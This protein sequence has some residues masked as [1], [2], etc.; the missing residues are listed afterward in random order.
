MLLG[1]ACNCNFL[2]EKWSI[3]GLMYQMIDRMVILS[4]KY[5]IR[6]ASIRDVEVYWVVKHGHIGDA[7]FD[8]EVG[9]FLLE[10]LKRMRQEEGNVDKIS[11]RNNESSQDR[12]VASS[13]T[14]TS[15]RN[16]DIVGS[17]VG[18]QWSSDLHS[19]GITASKLHIKF[20]SEVSSLKE[21]ADGCMQ[22]TLTTGKIF[23]VDLVVSAIGVD[24][25]PH[26]T[27][28]PEKDFTRAPDGGLVVNSRLQ[29]TQ[30]DVYAAGDCCSFSSKENALWFQMRLWSQ[31]KAMGILAAHCMLHIEDN[32]AS[33]MP[34]E[35]FIHVTRFLGKRVVL[36]GSYNGQGFE[37]YRQDQVVFYSRISGEG[38]D[39]NFIRVLVIHGRVQGAI[40]IGNTGLEE[41]MENLILDKL[42]VSAYGADL[43]DPSI[44]IDD[45]FD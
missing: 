15:G 5:T 4:D 3:S 24:P 30:K 14:A 13:T 1:N 34:F 43:L 17:S 42:D 29:T 25:A 31:A 10:E 21:I 6:R 23:E 27:W 12:E 38:S 32:M 28:L 16:G 36:L 19:Q 2:C 40:C 41:T 39:R 8:A 26:I 7:F 9:E 22:V 33:D 44:D 45:I 37:S 11:H 35:L 18:P 20:R